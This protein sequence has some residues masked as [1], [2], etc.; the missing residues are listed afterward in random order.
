MAAEKTFSQSKGFFAYAAALP[1]SKASRT[2]IASR[3]VLPFSAPPL[4][5]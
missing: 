2:G 1:V 4:S 5:A 3:K